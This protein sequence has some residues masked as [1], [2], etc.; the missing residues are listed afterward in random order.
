[1]GVYSLSEKE[2]FVIVLEGRVDN[3]WKLVCG[4]IFLIER[5]L[6]EELS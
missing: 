5:R 2:F 1:M 6:K 3:L 4:C